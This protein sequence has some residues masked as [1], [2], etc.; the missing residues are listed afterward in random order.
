MM[1]EL[2]ARSKRL[3]SNYNRFYKYLFLIFFIWKQIIVFVFHRSCL[4]LSKKFPGHVLSN[5]LTYMCTSLY[6]CVRVYQAHGGMSHRTAWC[7]DRVAW[8]G[9]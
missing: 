3:D 2:T 6:Y 8:Y 9:Q 1:N 5:V 7:D 4:W